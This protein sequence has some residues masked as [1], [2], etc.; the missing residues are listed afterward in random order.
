MSNA[1]VKKIL[2]VDDDEN[3][4]DIIKLIFE[5]EHYH[6]K[7]ILNANESELERSIADFR[8]DVILLD[9][10]IGQ[11]DGRDVCNRLKNNAETS[12]LPVIL[13]SAVNM[14][15]LSC[16]PDDT[17]EKPFDITDLQQKVKAL[18]DK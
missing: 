4:H 1:L 15:N 13:L 10:L 8:P 6:I 12:S 16:S 9:I 18:L 11:H 5:E 2:I 3:I 7:G 17:I 14:D